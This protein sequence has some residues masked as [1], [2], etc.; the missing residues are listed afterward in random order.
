M[1]TREHVEDSFEGNIA[2]WRNGRRVRRARNIGEVINAVDCVK[3][4]TRAY[5]R[6]QQGKTEQAQK[7]LARL[8]KIRKERE[9]ALAKRKAEQ[10]G[11]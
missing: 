11:Q 3:Y 2:A 6:R 7:D 5:E 1:L 8:A 4:R 10:E 9:E